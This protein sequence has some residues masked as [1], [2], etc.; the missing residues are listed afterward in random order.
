MY[1]TIFI[2]KSG[3]QDRTCGCRCKTIQIVS[4]TIS[5]NNIL[6]YEDRP[7]IDFESRNSISPE[8]WEKEWLE[9]INK[10]RTT[11]NGE[12]FESN[13]VDMNFTNLWKPYKNLSRN[14]NLNFKDLLGS[15]EILDCPSVTTFGKITR[16]P[17]YYK[18][19]PDGKKAYLHKNRFGNVWQV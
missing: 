17:I 18:I 5:N 8:Q 4:E 12:K 16:F 19:L 2:L 7:D 10:N 3:L 14:T 6:E 15:Y 11:F 1:D 13:L 9:I